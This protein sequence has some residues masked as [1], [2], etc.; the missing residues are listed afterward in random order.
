PRWIH[1]S[2]SA[3]SIWHPDT[4]FNMV[5]LGNIIYGLNPSGHT[6][7]LPFEVKPALSL[8]S[9]IVHVKKVEAGSHIGYGATY[10]SSEAE[11]IAT[12]PIGYADGMVRSLQGFHVL[13]DG[14][15]CEIVGR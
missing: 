9:E 11:W 13:V 8:V 2:N 5:R 4:V 10:T 14:K 1:A 15:S 3:T 7:E 6:L 12:V